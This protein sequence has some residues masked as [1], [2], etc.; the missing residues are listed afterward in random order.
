MSSDTSPPRLFT[1]VRSSDVN[2][3]MDF[4][5]HL[6]T[7]E[8]HR[9]VAANQP[10]MTEWEAQ[11]FRRQLVSKLIIQNDTLAAINLRPTSQR[12]QL[13]G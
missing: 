3:N 6:V 7:Q 9:R 2:Y 12:K 5:E 8:A 13:N 4:V 1:V 10:K 11:E